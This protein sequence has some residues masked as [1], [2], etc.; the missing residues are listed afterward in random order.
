[1]SVAERAVD[2]A[3]ARSFGYPRLKARHTH[4][5]TIQRKVVP[6]LFYLHAGYIRH[7]GF[8]GNVRQNLDAGYIRQYN[9]VGYIQRGA[10]G[11][12]NIRRPNDLGAAVKEARRKRGMNQTELATRLEV[13]RESVSRLETGDPGITLG[14]VLRALNVLGL[15]LAIDDA[16][17]PSERASDKPATSKPRPR[18][19]IDEI[20]DE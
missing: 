7:A 16:A 19:S 13:N 11:I 9:G 6:I 8:V 20:V 1:M 15:S 10:T 3:G 12:M 18:F 17:A 2:G 14:I 5:G 4:D